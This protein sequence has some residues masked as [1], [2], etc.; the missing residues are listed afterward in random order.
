MI[1]ALHLQGIP[2]G[3]FRVHGS[4]ILLAMAFDE[5]A[6]NSATVDSD[7]S[8]MGTPWVKFSYITNHPVEDTQGPTPGPSWLWP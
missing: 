8:L 6:V 1:A 3:V 7:R 2:I 4:L 5:T